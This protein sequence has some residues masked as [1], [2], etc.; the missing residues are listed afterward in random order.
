MWQNI[1]MTWDILKS[2]T[3]EVA[4]ESSE[5]WGLMSG[6]MMF[7]VLTTYLQWAGPNQLVRDPSDG[8]RAMMYVLAFGTALVVLQMQIGHLTHKRFEIYGSLP[9]LLCN[10]YLLLLSVGIHT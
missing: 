8:G 3:Y 9:F 5:F 2:K 1:E 4:F 10:A 7:V 6:Y